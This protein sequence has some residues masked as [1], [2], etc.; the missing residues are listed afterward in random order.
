MTLA[1][2]CQLPN[3]RYKDATSCEAGI[4]YYSILW[5]L[6]D[7][8]D[9]DILRDLVYDVMHKLAL[10]TFKKYVQIIVKYAEQDER[11][12]DIDTAMKIVKNIPL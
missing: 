11:F 9:F 2:W 6:H 10:C 3:G 12:K 4:F 8:Y 7:L 1:N 5:Q